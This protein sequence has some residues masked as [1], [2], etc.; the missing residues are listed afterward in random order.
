MVV[1]LPLLCCEGDDSSS[2]NAG[3][4]IAYGSAIGKRKKNKQQRLD[5][6]RYGSSIVVLRGR[7]G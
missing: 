7:Q 2:D 4:D 3:G 5:V 6:M 1:P